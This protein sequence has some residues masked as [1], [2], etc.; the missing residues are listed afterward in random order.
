MIEADH[1]T[2]RFGPLLAVDGV[3]FRI[4]RGTVAGFLGPNGAGKTTTMNML[5]G[6][7]APSAGRATIGGHDVASSPRAAHRCLG[8]LPEGAPARSEL[9]VTEYLRMRARLFGVQRSNVPRV[10]GQC[11]LE[12]V[13]G[14]VIGGL[15]RG[16]RQRVALAAALVHDPAALMLDEPGTGLDPVQQRAFRSL[17]KELAQ[18][19][20]I[21]FSTHQMSEAVELC[22]DL[23]IIGGG[24]LRT[25]SPLEVLREASTSMGDL[26]VESRG[27]DPKAITGS[28]DGCVVTTSAPVEEGWTQW[29]CNA[30]DAQR[31]RIAAE[32]A[33]QGGELR[34]LERAGVPLASHVQQLLEGGSS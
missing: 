32:V 3:S 13:R 8:W 31:S 2:R 18:D 15:S 28:V 22:D 24:R 25:H 7:L 34:R 16:F 23:L 4:D 20:A 29:T 11:G 1:L 12:E 27:V 30:S 19:R 17:V 5:A 9:R 33:R 26:H 14:R 21:L 10:L 6:V